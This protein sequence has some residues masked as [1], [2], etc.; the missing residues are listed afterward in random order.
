MPM[1]TPPP[2]AEIWLEWILF[3]SR[4]LLAPIY[5]GLAASLL[6]LVWVFLVEMGHML[7]NL[8]QMGTNDL[9]LGTLGLIDL[10]L[11]GNLIL[12]VIFSGY[13]NFVSKL[14][15]GVHEDRPAWAGTVDFSNLKL[16]LLASIV[17][18]SGIHLLKVF[19][20]IDKYPEA[21]VRWMVILHL[22]F[23]ASGV[24]LALMDW[25]SGLSKVNKKPV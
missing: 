25:V 13:E 10:S 20:D 17:A 12:I 14:E 3:H 19:M 11:A 7:L 23:V 18:I 24:L 1:A 4:W 6:M 8:P 15:V 16:K 9:I 22:V 21:Q 5:L 2:R